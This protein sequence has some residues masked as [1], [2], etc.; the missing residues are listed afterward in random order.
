MAEV[1]RHHVDASAVLKA[2]AADF[3]CVDNRPDL[4]RSRDGPVLSSHRSHGILPHSF[5]KGPQQPQSRVPG[6]LRVELGAVHP[7]CPHRAGDGN[8][9]VAH[10]QCTLR[11]VLAVVAVDVIDVFSLTDVLEQRVV[12]YNV[13]GVPADLRHLQALVRKVGLQ[14]ADLALHK[15]KAFV[16]TVLVA[17]FKQQLHPKADA[18]QRLP[19]GFFFHDRYKARR[20]QLGHCIGKMRPRPAG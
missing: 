4:L 19:F 1:H 17:L 12:L 15:A 11:T 2:Q 6:F 9:I 10:R 5:R 7:A 20:L 3:T 14:R 18:Q 16:L 13:Q 8:G